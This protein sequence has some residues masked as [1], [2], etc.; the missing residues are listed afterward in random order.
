MN[1]RGKNI[2]RMLCLILSWVMLWNSV[3]LPRVQAQESLGETTVATEEG[4]YAAW[5]GVTR[6]K[7]WELERCLITFQLTD[8]WDS[9]YTAVVTVENTSDTGI[10]NWHVA[11]PIAEEIKDLWNAQTVEGEQSGVVFKNVGWNQDIASGQSVQFGFTAEGEFRGFPEICELP[12]ALKA[13]PDSDAQVTYE[14]V[15]SW[16]NGFKGNI[17]IHNTSGRTIE[18]WQIS[19]D[20]PCEITD[21][22]EGQIVSNENGGYV[23]RN[24]AYNQ[25]IARMGL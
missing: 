7:S 11:F 1:K 16:E 21:L 22:W 20:L 4:T 15:E 5:D 13:V 2:R 25:N 23:V 19:F 8:C 24:K 3:E 17:G 12:T 9:G 10:E 14:V 6:E 18:D